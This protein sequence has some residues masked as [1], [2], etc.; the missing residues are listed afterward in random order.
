MIAGPMVFPSP[1]ISGGMHTPRRALNQSSLPGLRYLEG[2]PAALP[3]PTASVTQPSPRILQPNSQE[4][5][6]GMPAK[7]LPRGA[8]TYSNL[9]LFV[10][11]SERRLHTQQDVM[12]GNGRAHP[13]VGSPPPV[14]SLKGPSQKASPQ[15]LAPKKKGSASPSPPPSSS[16]PSFVSADVPKFH[17][18]PRSCAVRADHA[19]TRKLIPTAKPCPVLSAPIAS[20]QTGSPVVSAHGSPLVPPPSVVVVGGPQGFSQPG[21]ELSV[22]PS[23]VVWSDPSAPSFVV[24]PLSLVC[25]SQPCPEEFYISTPLESS[26]PSLIASSLSECVDPPL[27]QVNLEPS[28]ARFDISTPSGPSEQG[29]KFTAFSASPSSA[30]QVPVIKKFP[31]KEVT[32]CTTDETPHREGECQAATAVAVIGAADCAGRGGASGD[33]GTPMCLERGN[34]G[35]SLSSQDRYVYN[36]SSMMSP[37][38]GQPSMLRQPVGSVK[39]VVRRQVSPNSPRQQVSPNSPRQ[40]QPSLLRPP[41]QRSALR[42]R[43]PG[44]SPE[45]EPGNQALVWTPACATPRPVHQARDAGAPRSPSPRGF[46]SP[47][48]SRVVPAMSHSAV[49]AMAAEYMN[50]CGKYEDHLSE[51][52]ITC[53]AVTRTAS[54]GSTPRGSKA[55]TPER[56]WR[57]SCGGK[58]KD[59]TPERGW[60]SSRACLGGT[61][62]QSWR[63]TR[64]NCGSKTTTPERNWRS[65]CGSKVATPERS[66]R[67]STQVNSL[68]PQSLPITP[69]V[70]PRPAAMSGPTPTD[71]AL[72]KAQASAVDLPMVDSIIARGLLTD[73][74]RPWKDDPVAAPDDLAHVRALF[75]AQVPDAQIDNV[76]RVEN[77]GLSVVYG[78][79]RGTM[80]SNE[81]RLLWHGTSMDCV[82]NITLNGFNRAYCGRHGMKLGHG[83]YFSAAADYSMR[84]CDRRRKQRFMFLAKVLVGSWT[85]G[86]PDLIEP[87]HRDEERM[88]RYDSIVDN[89]ASPTV[90][91]VYRDFQALPLYLVEFSSPNTNQS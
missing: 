89:V 88:V 87:P 68:A 61:P 14:A 30:K 69:R 78:A 6:V 51:L 77:S 32:A 16:P 73:M 36:Q 21:V 19:S 59:T 52:K 29:P 86:S 28:P 58:A 18:A 44:A 70:R 22:T 47:P 11:A 3:R 57:P 31:G 54:K 74:T 91:C 66:W 67:A 5:C 75:A 26:E 63:S 17:P 2:T 46:L 8:P 39:D 37:R 49:E 41:E 81:E 62:E 84:F 9:E 20:P 7:M 76:Y 90:F 50:V 43:S 79:V 60:R 72:T 56:N 27:L 10:K 64:S 1:H 25:S 4:K 65:S 48:R 80:E 82:Q 33:I 34:A 12:V 71:I 35:D 55:S 53:A 42:G 40:E 38:L 13:R 23:F 83:T 85:T 15:T 24:P 45:K